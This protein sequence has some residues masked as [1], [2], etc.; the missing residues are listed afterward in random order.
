M[1]GRLSCSGKIFLKLCIIHVAMNRILPFVFICYTVLTGGCIPADEPEPAEEGKILVLMYHRIVN[2]E[3]GNLYERSFRD[4][5]SDLQ[6][7]IDNNI[8]VISFA[9]MGNTLSSGKMPK[10]NSVILTFDDGDNSWYNLVKPTLL[11]H[12]MPAT[13]FLWTYMV[14]HDSFITWEEIEDMS[15]YT[16]PGGKR[17]FVFGSHTYSHQ[18]L[19]QRKGDF[20]SDTEYN[21]FLDYEMGVSRELIEEHTPGNVTILSL[22]YGDGAGDQEIIAAAARNGY[23]FIRTSVWAAIEDAETSFYEIPGLPMLD[24]TKSEIIG[25]YLGM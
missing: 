20:S 5:E 7:I 8:N 15:F 22:P 11:K 14:G 2:G 23:E 12:K 4:L 10:G 18:Y 3:P 19:Y 16:L 9:E 17:P 13:F 1:T 21:S 6:Y 25:S 24:A